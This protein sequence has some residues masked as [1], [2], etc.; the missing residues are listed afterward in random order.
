MKE[1]K[2]RQAILSSKGDFLYFHYWGFTDGHFTSP[3]TTSS[4][5]EGAAKNSA[6]YT[7]LKDR[8]GKEIY[9]GDVVA[10]GVRKEKCLIVFLDGAFCIKRSCCVGY[11]F[12]MENICRVIGNIYENPE[13]IATGREIEA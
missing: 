8:T 7:G 12:I 5:I 2:F 4:T 3:E 9:E 10:V 1:L 13:L 11:A 6:Q